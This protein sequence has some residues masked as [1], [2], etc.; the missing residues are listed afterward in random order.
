MIPLNFLIKPASGACNMRCKYCFYENEVVI[1][2]E[3]HPVFMTLDTAQL[4][5]YQ[6]FSCIESEKRGERN[7]VPISFAFQ[8][9]EPTLAGL[10]FFNKF[11][12]MVQTYNVRKYPVQYTIQT[13]GLL[14][15]E[16]WADFFAKNNFLVGISIDGD[17]ALHESLRPDAVGRSTWDRVTRNLRLLQDKHVETN[18]LCVVTRQCAKHPEK[19]YRAL[20]NLGVSFLQFIPCLDPL[21]VPRGSMPYSLTPKLYG[22]FLCGLFDEW[23]W[24]WKSGHY[25]SIRLFDDYIHLAM[26]LPAGTC[27]TSGSCGAY[28]VV[29][30]DGTLYPCD[31]YCLNEWKIG[32]LGEASLAEYAKSEIETHFLEEGTKHPS[33]CS[34]CRF[35]PLC[36][37]GCKR[38]WY[39]DSDG[40]N[41]NYFCS[42]FSQFFTY[43][44]QRILEIARRERQ[45]IF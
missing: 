20:K 27:A 19:Y 30:G 15:N 33:E 13:N 4:L 11:I 9:G 5:I 6:A 34:S 22:N 39:Q 14:L 31:F 10:D 43:A 21:D 3:D 37:G 17:K 8:G 2:K 7:T 41:H 35:Y 29:E 28:F 24:D 44:E 45:F 16:E 32:K 1:R 23:Y 12:E 25:T 18:L 42:S 38:D 36:F 40:K 26:G